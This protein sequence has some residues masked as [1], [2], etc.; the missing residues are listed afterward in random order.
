MWRRQHDTRAKQALWKYTADQSFRGGPDARGR[1]LSRTT[2]GRDP[3]RWHS[4]STLAS[5][6]TRNVGRKKMMTSFRYVASILAADVDHTDWDEVDRSHS[7]FYIYLF[8]ASKNLFDFSPLHHLSIDVIFCH[9]FTLGWIV[10]EFFKVEVRAR[11]HFILFPLS[12]GLAKTRPRSISRHIAIFV[13]ADYWRTE[14]WLVNKCTGIAIPF[15]FKVLWTKLH[16][17]SSLQP[18]LLL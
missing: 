12:W 15:I 1:R 5:L 2:F 10:D 8:E 9:I 18:V 13:I 16:R 6:A 7:L 17:H 4:R 14:F 11:L 3:N